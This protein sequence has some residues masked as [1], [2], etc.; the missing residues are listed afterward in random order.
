MAE[1]ASATIFGPTLAG[2]RSA[3]RAENSALLV[4][5]SAGYLARFENSATALSADHFG[6]SIRG[7]AQPGQPSRSYGQSRRLLSESFSALRK[8]APPAPHWR[9]LP[10]GPCQAKRENR[11]HG[12]RTD[13]LPG[14]TGAA[15]LGCARG[16]LWH[17]RPAPGLRTRKRAAIEKLARGRSL[18]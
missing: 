9:G 6:R 18:N 11:R 14:R 2:L 1:L 12:D 7:G 4:H 16:T 17:N 13:N 3:A 5:P 15:R 8:Y 10:Q